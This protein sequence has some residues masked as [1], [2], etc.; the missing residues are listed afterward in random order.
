MDYTQQ[1]CI[2]QSSGIVYSCDCSQNCNTH[3]QLT[4][5]L[6]SVCFDSVRHD[7]TTGDSKNYSCYECVR[8]PIT[9]NPSEAN[10]ASCQETPNACG[11]NQTLGYGP[12]DSG[13]MIMELNGTN[14]VYLGDDTGW[15]ALGSGQG[16]ECPAENNPKYPNLYPGFIVSGPAQSCPN[17]APNA[18]YVCIACAVSDQCSCPAYYNW[19][20][21]IKTNPTPGHW[22]CSGGCEPC[23]TSC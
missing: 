14:Y 7:Y 22:P 10:S 12:C 19:K 17:Y 11:G 6:C 2:P 21:V 15:Q 4:S 20:P 9:E 1:N 3:N 5:A 23:A 8:K 18:P 13:M 16:L